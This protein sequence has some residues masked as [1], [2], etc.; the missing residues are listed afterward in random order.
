MPTTQDTTKRITPSTNGVQTSDVEHLFHL[1]NYK[2]VLAVTLDRGGKLANN[3]IASY[4]IG[5]LVYLGRLQEAEVLSKS[6][7]W[8][9]AVDLARVNYFLGVGFT[10]HFDFAKGRSYFG[11]NLLSFRKEKE[12]QGIA[13]YAW[14]GIGFYRFWM[15]PLLRAEGASSKALA[16]AIATGRVFERIIAL[17]LLSHLRMNSG[18]FRAGFATFSQA[19][20]L[21]SQF[22]CNWVIHAIDVAVVGYRASSGISG[23][24]AI[25]E[26]EAVLKKQ[27]LE[28]S[29]T[30]SQLLIELARQK[31]LRGALTD[32]KAILDEAC[33]AVYQ[34]QNP[35][36]EAMLNTRLATLLYRRGE[37][38]QALNLLRNIS[39]QLGRSQ[40]KLVQLA[41]KGLE[42]KILTQLGLHAEADAIKKELANLIRKTT[43]FQAQRIAKRDAGDYF[44][45]SSPGQDPLGDL[46]DLVSQKRVRA[47]EEIIQRGY[48]GLL[49]DALGISAQERLIYLNLNGESVTI[50]NRGDIVHLQSPASDLSQ[51]FLLALN[52]NDGLS[53]EELC[54]LVWDQK[55][56][57]LRHDPLI[58]AVV[59]RIRKIHPSLGQWLV[60]TESGYK[61]QDGI[62]VRILS[63]TL[64]KTASPTDFNTSSQHT[65]E[66]SND[67]PAAPAS[68]T[69]TIPSGLNVRQADI[70]E[71]AKQKGDVDAKTVRESCS[72]SEMTATRDLTWLCELGYLERVGK[73]RATRYVT[74]NR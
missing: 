41:S 32:A 64:T 11:Q 27:K 49:P 60:G 44:S 73:G 50:F 28:D 39:H 22:G 62:E 59:S 74:I 8:D 61:L 6:I 66:G 56:N 35:R 67:W 63:S 16:A 68:R 2:Q 72:V 15:G 10:R 20:E 23:D 42:Q 48:L 31:M 29:Y 34:A 9:E 21:A 54:K 52:H 18:Q 14:L 26:L 13:L 40:H 69:R 57:P 24:Q 36:L 43:Q 25:E 30:R 65:S 55:Y 58:Y 5:A 47:V 46:I 4:M 12:N 45:Q 3:T 17:D 7:K 38:H 51:R 53:K 33:Q 1:G 37:N 19:R 71:L 70:L